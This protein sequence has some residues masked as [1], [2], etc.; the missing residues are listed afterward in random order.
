MRDKG[1]ITLRRL[2]MLTKDELIAIILDQ[3][4]DDNDSSIQNDLL[5]DLVRKYVDTNESLKKTLIEVERLSNIDPLTGLYNRHN[6]S[7]IFDRELTRFNRYGQEF[8]IVLLD[9]D[10]FKRVNDTYGHNI[11]D[12]VLVDVGQILREQ[13]RQVDIVARWGGEEFIVLITA[14][15]NNGGTLL[16]ERIRKAIE[17][18]KFPGVGKVTMSLG[19]AEVQSKDTLSVIT[20]RADQALYKAKETGR[21]KVVVYSTEEQ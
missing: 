15:I 7:K 16:A 18:H 21:N 2:R 13:I 11:G 10:F 14:G 6:F 9:I 1:P 12:D 8:C 20:A 4:A 3:M 5:Y 19:I 17:G